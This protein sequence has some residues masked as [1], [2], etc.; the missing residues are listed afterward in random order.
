M[1]DDGDSFPKEHLKKYRTLF[2]EELEPTKAA[3]YLYQYSVFD[4][5]THDEIVEECFRLNKAK[6]ILHHLSDKSP[7]CLKI[8]GQVLIHSKQD[9]IITML[10]EREGRNSLT[11]KGKSWC[12]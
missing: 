7:R 8:F 2:L 3:D 4:K 6:L 12:Y 1:E 10:H 11:P 5:I 9:F